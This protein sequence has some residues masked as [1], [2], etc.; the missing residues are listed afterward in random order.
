MS[1]RDYERISVHMLFGAYYLA[2]EYCPEHRWV[3]TGPQQSVGLQ[4]NTG[5]CINSKYI[6]I[7]REIE[8]V[9]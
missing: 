1:M 5:E 8:A 4:Q 3:G 7:W 9:K 6:Y 2:G